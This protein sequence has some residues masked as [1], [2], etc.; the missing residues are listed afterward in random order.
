MGECSEWECEWG[1]EEECQWEGEGEWAS[2][3]EVGRE[4]GISVRMCSE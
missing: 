1:T 2:V 3:S 4:W